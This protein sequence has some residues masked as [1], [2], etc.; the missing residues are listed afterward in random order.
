SHSHSPL[1]SPPRPP[2]SLPDAG[3]VCAADDAAAAT[4]TGRD[5][6]MDA[7]LG[8]D[9]L[10]GGVRALSATAR[11]VTVADERVTS[12]P[13]GVLRRLAEA[14]RQSGVVFDPFLENEI[15]SVLAGGHAPYLA[16]HTTSSPPAALVA[17]PPTS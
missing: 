1:S 14:C 5:A 4:V 7:S 11:D 16:P 13:G 9:E 2:P 15:D 3:H 12:S 8:Y 17:P 6:R 10:I